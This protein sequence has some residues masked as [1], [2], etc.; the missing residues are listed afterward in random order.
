M[1]GVSQFGEPTKGIIEKIYEDT[2]QAINNVHPLKIEYSF[3]VANTTQKN[4][5]IVW[6]KVNGKRPNGEHL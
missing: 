6:D 4:H 3:S 2:N 1:N 5:I